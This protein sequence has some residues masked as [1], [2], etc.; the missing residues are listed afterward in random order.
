VCFE[1][2]GRCAGWHGGA[3]KAVVGKQDFNLNGWVSAR[4][5]NFASAYSGNDGQGVSFDCDNSQ[6]KK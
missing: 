2:T 1:G 4:V 5:K 3:T 6:I